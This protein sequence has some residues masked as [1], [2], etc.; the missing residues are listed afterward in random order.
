MKDI[1]TN[2]I[3]IKYPSFYRGVLIGKGVNNSASNEVILNML[4]QSEKD[5][6]SDKNLKD[7]KK[8]PFI[9]TWRD[10]HKAFGSNP[11]DHRPSIESLI[12]RVRGGKD[13]PYINT[14]V[15]LFNYISLKYRIPCG[16]DDVNSI[17]GNPC[18]KLS[19]GSE[20]FTPFNDPDAIENPNIGEV[21]Y[22]D[23]AKVMCRK[24]NWRQGDQT[25]ITLDTKNIIINV[26]GL[27][28]VTKETINN[29]TMEL[30]KLL[31]DH[32]GGEVSYNYISIDNPVIEI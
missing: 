21:I 25:K 8:Y 29:A 27:A 32:C 24:W 22:A 28:P 15:A 14:L 11:K 30:A 26:D 23:D 5:V 9:E 31:K 12:N 7:F 10:A 4:R 1:I 20:K 13:I 18:L 17:I 19:D 16:G 3:F 6:R 2:E